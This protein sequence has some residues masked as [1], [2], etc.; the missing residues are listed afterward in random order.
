[1]VKTYR[2]F[3]ISCDHCKQT[4][5]TALVKVDGVRLVEVDVDTKT[6]RV[7]GDA[8]PDDVKAAIVESGYDVAEITTT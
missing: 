1:V 5:E 7:A 8:D 2:A 6:I 4:I 3:G